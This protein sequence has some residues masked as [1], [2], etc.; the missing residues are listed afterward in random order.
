MYRRMLTI[1][2]FEEQ[3]NDLYTR[4]ADARPGASLYRRRSRS[5][6]RLR[7]AAERRLHYQH[8]SRSRALRREGRR[9]G[10][11]VRRAARQGSWVLQRQ[12]R[13]DAHRGSGHRQSGRKCDCRRKHRYRDR[14][15]VDSQT[16]GY[17]AGRCLL[18]R[19]GRIGTGSALRGDEHG[20]AVEAA[21]HLRLR[22]QHVQRVH[23]LFGNHG[24]RHPDARQRIRRASARVPTGRTRVR[25]TR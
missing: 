13:L 18:L 12:G 19:R 2:L 14:C 15:S 22:K 21:D 20:G 5:R 3:V 16:P 7:S 4:G 9:A 24:G 17:G 1:R 6:G 11:D 25:S 8:A 10:P 23:T